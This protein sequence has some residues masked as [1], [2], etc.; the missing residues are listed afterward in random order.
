MFYDA[1]KDD[2]ETKYWNFIEWLTEQTVERIRS[3]GDD[4]I[5]SG[6]AWYLD[7]AYS[8]SLSSG[9]VIDF[10]CVSSDSVCERLGFDFEKNKQLIEWFDRLNPTAFE[11]R[12]GRT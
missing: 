1:E 3:S 9:E 7:T 2:D 6:V 4:S 12:Y 5:E 8:A 10:F 11:R